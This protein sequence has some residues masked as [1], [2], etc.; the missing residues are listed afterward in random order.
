M[1]CKVCHSELNDNAIFCPKCGTPIEKKASKFCPNCGT[2]ANDGDLF[3]S[4]CG[5]RFGDTKELK[6]ENCGNKIKEDDVFCPNCGHKV[7]SD[8][9]NN[10]IIKDNFSETELYRKNMIGYYMGL[11][12]ISGTFVITNKKITYTPLAMYVF[13]KPF[14]ISMN[15]ITGAERASVMGINL[16]IRIN[17]ISGKGHLFALGIQNSSD[18][19]PVIDLINNNKTR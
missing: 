18:I 5:F 12:Q 7:R 13:N 19:Q 17:T 4:N 8:G 10:N 1:Q 3:C 14:E 11:R 9:E 6:C 15:E 2:K 16:C